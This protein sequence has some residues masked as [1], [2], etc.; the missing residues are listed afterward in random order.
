MT[1]CRS[2]G[3]TPAERRNAALAFAAALVT[4]AAG[5]ALSAGQYPEQPYDWVYVVMSELASRKHNPGGGGWFA[6]ALGISMLALWPVANYLARSM[7]GARRWPVLALRAA[8][9]CGA[10]MAL[11]RLLFVHLSDVIY[12]SHELLA[13]GVF[14]GLYA[15]VL[16]LYAQRACRDPRLLPGALLVAAP[17]A[18][19]GIT[20]LALY[21]DQRDFGWVDHGWRALGIPFWLSFAFW[22]WVA[23][24]LLWV[25]LGHLLWSVPDAR[26]R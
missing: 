3:A 17:L 7:T 13:I 23:V 25:G 16:G 12:K 5:V 2:S 6:I 1:S 21:L 14:A 9:G 8:I 18:A 26:S 22:Q 11:E 4:F 24:A 20:Q 10:A 15:G 19:I